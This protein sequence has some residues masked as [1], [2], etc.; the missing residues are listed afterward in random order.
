MQVEFDFIA[1][2]CILRLHGRFFT[3]SEA[4][5]TQTLEDLR[6]AG[7][8]K[9]VVDCS[10]LPYIDS[11]GIAYLIGLHNF[12]APRSGVLA[13]ANVNDRVHEVLQITQL[14]TVLPIFTDE[15]AASRAMAVEAAMTA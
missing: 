15:I 8:R 10:D 1:D 13:L 9:I 11:T 6:K 12:A 7:I 4:E 2:V 5:L 14:D 3:G